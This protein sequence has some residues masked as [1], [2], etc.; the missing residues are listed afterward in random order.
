MKIPQF[1][2]DVLGKFEAD[3][4]PVMEAEVYDSLYSARGTQGDLS[5][6]DFEGFRAEISAFIF[7]RRPD[8]DSPWGTYFAPTFTGTKTDGTVVRNPDIA[9]LSANVVSH[10]QKRAETT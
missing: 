10:W 2:Q 1:V 9:E 7:D 6:E 4:R 3:V 5:N 8:E